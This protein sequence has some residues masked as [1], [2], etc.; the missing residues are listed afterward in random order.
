MATQKIARLKKGETAFY[1]GT[2]YGV[3][4]NG[5]YAIFRNDGRIAWSSESFTFFQQLIKNAELLKTVLS[6]GEIVG[7]A[8]DNWFK[9]Q[10]KS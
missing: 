9:N 5:E 7:I 2:K 8:H 4:V 1:K 6:F 3:L 10:N